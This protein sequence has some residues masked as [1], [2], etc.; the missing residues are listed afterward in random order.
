[1]IVKNGEKHLERCL[2]SVMHVVDEM[3]VVDTGST[4]R[5]KQIAESLGAKV[6]DFEWTD[7]FAD[8]RNF[9]LQQSTGDWN[10][11]LDA[12]EYLI[13]DYRQQV[14]NFVNQRKAIGRIKIVS[15]F[16]HN[17][18]IRYA[19]GFASRLFPRG[20]YYRGRIHEQV[21]SDLPHVK[22]EIVAH[23]DGYFETDKTGR[24]IAL[25]EK[26]LCSD[27]NNAYLLF[28]LARE[29]RQK[30]DQQS[31]CDYYRKAYQLASKKDGYFGNLVVEYLYAL[32][33]VGR[34]EEAFS[35]IQAESGHLYTSPDFHFATGMFY[36]DYILSHL[37]THMDKLWLIE[38]AFQTC[39]Q[40]GEEGRYDGVVGT[41][42]FLAAYNLGV[43]YEVTGDVQ[44]AIRYYQ[45]SAED[46]Y[47]PAVNRLQLLLAGRN[48]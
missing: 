36:M 6:F 15:K 45:Q 40:L 7:S 24:N 12:D 20:V 1:M 37:S 33:A 35:L 13:A 17:G 25:L 14:R 34:L 31:A 23:H 38:K 2:R 39:L 26:E 30:N 16:L 48:E 42:S 18:E 19:Q 22:T 44:K 41:G 29:Y 27:P 21:V 8:A 43:Y 3:I 46:G 11:V 9:A 47:Q 32:M 28:Q 5:T 4:D 10:L